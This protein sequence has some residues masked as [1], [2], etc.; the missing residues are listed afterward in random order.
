MT[1]ILYPPSRPQSVGEI[2]DSGFRI[3]GAT[4]P[5]CLLYAALGVIAGQLPTIY[6]LASGRTIAQALFMQRVRDPVWWVLY[7]V[8]MVG[9]VMFANA[10]LLRQHALAS[11]RPAASG[12][13]A[14]ALRHVGGVLLIWL[15]VGC[16]LVIPLSIV[17]AAVLAS[18]QKLTLIV[19]F[20]VMLIP[21]SWILVRWSCAVTAYLLTEH[22]PVA[23]MG[24]SWE[25]TRGHFWRLTLIYTVGLVLLLVLY[26]LSGVLGGAVAVLLAHGDVLMITATSAAVVVLLGAVVTPFYWAFGLAVFGDLSVRREGGDLAQRLAAPAAQ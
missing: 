12:E 21:L 23:S 25:L 3:F 18:P 15:L 6:E 19:I 11:G 13:L 10:V 7:I 4:L 22:G 8:A 5:K 17:G 9:A 14:T 20:A 16:A 26:T 1:N 2:L 24:Y